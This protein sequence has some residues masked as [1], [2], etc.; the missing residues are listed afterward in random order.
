MIMVCFIGILPSC[1]LPV[2][3]LD[4]RDVRFGPRISGRAGLRHRELGPEISLP[5]VPICP[6]SIEPR[7][8][9]DRLPVTDRF[10]VYLDER[11]SFLVRVMTLLNV[12]LRSHVEEFGDLC[13]FRLGRVYVKVKVPRAS[14]APLIAARN[15]ARFS[16]RR[17]GPSAVDKA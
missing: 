9:R 3:R 6:S 12:W 2:G 14:T 17:D 15:S 1:I 4:P 13:H 8:A 16:P 11:R 5:A 10:R 7:T